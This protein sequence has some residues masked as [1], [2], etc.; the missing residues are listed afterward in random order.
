MTSPSFVT[1]ASNV[2]G[3]AMAFLGLSLLTTRLG[4]L[5]LGQGALTG[6]GAIAAMHSVNDYGL[7]PS[8]M[9]LV[10]LAVGF[11]A[12]ALIAI[13]S[14][15][16]PGAYLALLTLSLAVAF[17]IIL[18]QIDGPLPVLLGNT[19]DKGFQPVEF[20]PPS[21]TGID[22]ADEH[23]WEYWVIIIWAVVALLLVR[24][25]LRGPVGRAFIACRD[26]PLAAAA[27]GIPVRRTRLFGVALS[28][29]LAGFGGALLVIP[30]P[31]TDQAQYP[32][33]LSIKMFALAMVTRGTGALGAIPAATF[34][35]LLPVWLED[36]GW[37]RDGELIGLLRSEGFIYAALLLGTAYLS[38]G[39]GAGAIYQRLFVRGTTDSKDPTTAQQ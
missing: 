35:V 1:E 24:Q 15:R 11:V 12:G 34:L 6:V 20:L 14:L 18:R 10:G 21:W 5:S 4:L 31:F 26:D 30:T 25:L 19:T 22:D 36:R 7:P 3:F 9:P 2:V 8:L 32:E 38:K 29:A 13:P 23:L 28:G 16:L 27:F 37:V 39:R 17:P 33:S